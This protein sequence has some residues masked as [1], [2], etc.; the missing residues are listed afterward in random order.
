MNVSFSESSSV[1]PLSLSPVDITELLVVTVVVVLKEPINA[2][3][4]L[5]N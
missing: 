5:P 3:I 2:P 4:A 1:K